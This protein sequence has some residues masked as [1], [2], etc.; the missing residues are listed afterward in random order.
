MKRNNKNKWLVEGTLIAATVL[1]VVGCGSE[2]NFG[3]YQMES[4]GVNFTNEYSSPSELGV[5]DVMYVNFADSSEAILDFAKVSSSEKFILAVG[6]ANVS[7]GAASVQLSSDISAVVEADE[8]AKLPPDDN[9]TPDEVLSAWLRAAEFDLAATESIP[10]EKTIGMKAMSVTKAASVGDTES[11]RILSSLSSTT[12]YTMVDGKVRCI[13]D[14]VIFYVDPRVTSD[15]LSNDN[16]DLLCKE[17]N[18][19]AKDEQALF[20]ETSD[21]NGDGR[22]AILM[23]PQINRLGSLGGGI[24]TGYFWAGDLYARSS[25]NPVSNERE[26]I[27]TMVPD[28]TGTYG[29]SVSKE[30]ALGNLLPAVLPHELQHA[31]NYNQHVLSKGAPPEQNW[32]NEGL[33]HLAEDLMGY[34]QENPSRY[35]LYLSNTAVAGLVTTAQPNL[36]ER[37]AAYLFLRYL[38]EQSSSGDTFLRRL[39]QTSSVGVDNLEQAF[40]GSAGFST[41][42]E[43]MAR[44]T[45]ALAMTNEGLTLDSRYTY[46]DRVKNSATGHWE[47]VCL[48]CDADD[49][50]GTILS[51]VEKLSYSGASAATI[52][53]SAAQF[54]SISS[55][56]ARIA[57]NGSGSSNFGVLIR[58]Q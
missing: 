32:L 37:G 30:F 31:I 56:P 28:P 45:A 15:Q 2:K 41:F 35:A 24:I 46:R 25:S 1:L 29:V 5:G 58:Q 47:G 53:G 52:A 48:K 10:D 26:I 55:V 3:P 54:Y 8:S 49:G 9:Y 11:F 50:R 16:I 51:G 19:V 18:E 13:G 21:I 27:Y 40:A 34:G 12:T 57:L 23:T 17:F 22:L 20:G 36:Y 38:Y 39:V 43:F 6:A 14:A 42:T 44:W 33:S 7:G 4:G